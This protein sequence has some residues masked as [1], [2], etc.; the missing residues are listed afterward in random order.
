MH[1][2]NIQFSLNFVNSWHLFY[3]KKKKFVKVQY[4][5]SALLH[6][7]T[8]SYGGCSVTVFKILFDLCGQMECQHTALPCYNWCAP[9]NMFH[10]CHHPPCPLSF[11]FRFMSALIMLEFVMCYKRSSHAAFHSH[12]SLLFLLTF[13]KDLKVH[14]ISGILD[15]H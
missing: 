2:Q 5:L 1:L 15:L 13:P 7:D 8:I 10:L 14:T 6:S 11:Q 12:S 4:C 9:Y 3:E